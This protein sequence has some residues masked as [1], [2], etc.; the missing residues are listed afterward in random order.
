MLIGM[1]ESMKQGSEESSSC[2][3]TDPRMLS[4]QSP[5]HRDEREGTGGER[6]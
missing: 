1:G 3:E 6:V 2:P 5:R 4:K